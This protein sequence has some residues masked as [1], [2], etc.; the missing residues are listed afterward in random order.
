V[1]FYLRLRLQEGFLARQREGH[2]KTRLA[3]LTSQLC[4]LCLP[5][6]LAPF[7]CVRTFE[8]SLGLEQ[9]GLQALSLP[10]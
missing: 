4:Q 1:A 3:G 2:K 7:A 10:F 5:S 8:R 9:S 6:L